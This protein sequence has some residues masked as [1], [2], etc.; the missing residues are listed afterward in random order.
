MDYEKAKKLYGRLKGLQQHAFHSTSIYGDA[1]EGFNK[2]VQNLKEALEDTEIL[3][4]LLPSDAF[5]SSQVSHELFCSIDR[6]QNRILELVSYLEYGYNLTD[7]VITTGSIYN[8]IKDEKLKNRCS[9]ILAAPGNFDR[10]INQATQVLED[11]IRTKARLDR[12]FIG[13]TLV[14]KAL[15]PDLSKT[16]LQVSSSEDEHRGF[17][18]ICRGIMS[19]FRNPT[20]HMLTD[21]YSRDEALKLCAFIDDLLISLD[22]AKI[23]N[24]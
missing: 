17:C 12:S 20:H 2:I 22:D 15:N 4:F 7:R 14:N 18:D 23:I 8:S 9:D 19:A 11:R 13:V 6:L 10:V 3:T 24:K 5:Y 1:G 16:I 21:Q